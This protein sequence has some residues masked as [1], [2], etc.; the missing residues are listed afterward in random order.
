MKKL[1]LNLRMALVINGV[2]LVVLTVVIGLDA[3]RS[4]DYART[5]ASAQAQE[6]ALR[7]ARDVQAQLDDVAHTVRVVAQTF[8][9]MKSAWVD[10]RS[11]LNGTLSQ[12]LKANPSLLTI[13]SCWDPDAFDGKDKD[14]ANKA[15]HD[16]TGRF[17]PLW[18]RGEKD[19]VLDKF[20]AYAAAGAGNYYLPV[21]GSGHETLFDPVAQRFGS[22]E[23]YA[24]VVAAPVRYNGEVVAVVGAHVDMAAIAKSV[25]GIHPFETGYA[26]LASA[27]GRI[28]AHADTTQVGNQ[29][30]ATVLRAVQAATTAVYAYARDGISG[31]LKTDTLEVHVPIRIDQAQETWM[32]SVYIPT[33]RVLAAAR[34]AMYVSAALGFLA[35]LFL[36]GVVHVFSRSIT[37]P[38]RQLAG[39]IEQ[40]T[41]GIIETSDQLTES[42]QTL[43]DGASAQA[44]SLQEAS[45]SLEETASVAKNN[46]DSATQMNELARQTREAADSS[47]RGAQEMGTAMAAIKGSSD[48]IAKI[49]KTIDEIAFQTNILA[50]NA[51]VEA[52]RAGEAGAGFAVV[53]EEVRR[54]AQRAA[55]AAKETEGKI[56]DAIE[57][58]A[59]GVA[60]SGKVVDSLSGIAVTARKV[61]DLAAQMSRASTEQAQGIAQINAAVSQL[62]SVTQANAAGAEQTSAA[63][64]ELHGRAGAMKL[65]ADAL[66]KLVEGAGHAPVPGAVTTAVSPKPTPEVTSRSA[67]TVAAAPRARVNRTPAVQSLFE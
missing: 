29:V 40:T 50:L 22:Q 14:F 23:Y 18:Y 59:E 31:P 45:A 42:S 65:S 26:G 64:Q 61:N 46:A 57:K 47:M 20:T 63:A 32:L 7:Y 2:I 6:V 49:I 62:D 24:A 10:D 51:A 5:A 8:E 41:T 16:A 34:H 39:D 52:A 21:K 28:V 17:I 35:L 9:G 30:D 54:L 15:G 11:L 48:E 56:H 37:K 36:N 33:D 4:L 55:S 38:L 58:T 13:W 19:V 60:V 1:P 67:P 3:R 25:A 12:I 27:S 66:L 43:A 53:A 44:A